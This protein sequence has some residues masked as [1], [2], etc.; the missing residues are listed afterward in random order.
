MS[1]AL[2]FMR[3][4]FITVKPYLTIK[5]LLIF[6]A[7]GLIMMISSGTSVTAIGII[8]TF[9]VLYVSY[10]FAV[11]EK[12]GID[13][14]YATLSLTRG[15]VVLGR[16]LFAF[17]VELCAAL[18]ALLLST[19]MLIIM[20]KEVNLQELLV[21]TMVVFIIFSI[22]QAFQLPLYFK[23]GYA[24]AKLVAYLPFLGFP[25]AVFLL[26]GMLKRSG[27]LQPLAAAPEWAL[28]N[29]LIALC[30]GIALWASMVFLS[31]RM[32]LAFYKK[33]DV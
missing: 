28:A 18:L 25:L 16:Y 15:S 9:G 4:D 30:L 14:L 19:G 17:F 24:K 31:Y 2:S 20:Q 22:M 1:K 12:N 8:M 5:N 27:V 33:R 3:L 11:G 29:P 6:M 10:P 13:A 21:T 23:L 26:T 7:V 32:S